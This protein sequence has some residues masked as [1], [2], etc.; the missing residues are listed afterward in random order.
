MATALQYL[1]NQH[2]WKIAG[3]VHARLPVR[4]I[5]DA[6]PF[7]ISSNSLRAFIIGSLQLRPR[8]QRGHSGRPPGSLSKRDIEIVAARKDGL[9]ARA[10]G[11]KFGISFQRVNQILKRD[12]PELMGA[13]YFWDRAR[14]KY[15][16]PMITCETCERTVR[17]NTIHGA[18]KQRFC[19][20]LN[21]SSCGVIRSTPLKERRI[22][23]VAVAN[24]MRREKST[25]REVADAVG[26]K[27]KMYLVVVVRRW[28]K[29]FGIDVTDTYGL[30]GQHRGLSRKK[31]A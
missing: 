24:R 29:Q 27:D 28:G 13:A 22:E 11:C 15:P 25:W 10:I 16:W 7:P 4:K 8:G 19:G 9:S 17:A 31:A 30:H 20:S 6:L 23:I 5:V 12:A 3:M 1:L 26:Y 21:G 18:A 2:R 14:E